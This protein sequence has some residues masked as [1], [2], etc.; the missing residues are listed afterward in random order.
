ML[1]HGGFRVLWFETEMILKVLYVKGS[2]TSLW[3]YWE[4]VKPLRFGE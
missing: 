1:T 4:V 2:D 3:Y